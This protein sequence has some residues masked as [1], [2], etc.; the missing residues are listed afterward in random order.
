MNIPKDIEKQAFSGTCEYYRNKGCSEF[1]QEYW[2]FV[3]KLSEEF[4]EAMQQQC[5]HEQEQNRYRVFL[6]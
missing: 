4:I 6:L 3:A 2:W 5:K 1:V